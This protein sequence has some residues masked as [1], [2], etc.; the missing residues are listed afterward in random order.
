MISPA[1]DLAAPLSAPAAGD[2]V[3]LRRTCAGGRIRVLET[4]FDE[5][6]DS[7]EGIDLWI[8]HRR[9]RPV[10]ESG[11]LYFY[12]L[13]N[14]LRPAPEELLAGM[15]KSTAKG[16]RG[17]MNSRGLSCR[18][19]DAPGASELAAFADQYDAHPLNPGQ[20]PVDRAW[21]QA[22]G[23]TGSLRLVETFDAGGTL[24]L[25]R[26]MQCF[27]ASGVVQP[28]L[29]ATRYQEETDPSRAQALGN[30]NRFSYYMEFLHYREQ[31]YHTFDHNGWYAG[32]ED[33][34]RL[35]INQFKENFGGR[36][37]YFYECEEPVSPRGRLYV[38]LRTLR[39][40]WFQ[41]EQQKEWL[42]RRQKAPSQPDI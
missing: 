35:G 7:L 9:S 4:W 21:I 10:S 17:A 16:I 24:L 22:L 42:R 26:L 14:D 39:R 8:A 15:R 28:V 5:D 31:G 3:R 37:C 32:L 6:P 29:A 38:L 33:K 25:Q 34:K 20:P 40:R 23:A 11:W 13:L 18:F 1:P 19:N 12:T 36:V 30:A 2:R 27:P 41:P